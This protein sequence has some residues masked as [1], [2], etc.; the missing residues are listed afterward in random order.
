MRKVILF[1][2]SS[3]DG[4]IASISG[5]VD[6]LFHDQ[7]YGYSSFIA[8]VD[9]VV[10]GRRTYEQILTFGDYPYPGT[11]GYVF[12]KTR[13]GERDANVEFVSGDVA[14]FIADLKAVPGKNI[15]LV[16]GGQLNGAF[17]QQ[18][19]I[20]EFVVSTTSPGNSRGGHPPVSGR[21]GRPRI[22]LATL[23]FVRGRLGP[24][25]LRPEFLTLASDNDHSSS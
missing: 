14:R 25:N 7:D 11:T 16:G 20:D 6:W 17:L 19:L 3:L 21:N 8:G 10:M 13:S 15:W 12:S 4:F 1:I 5:D 22:E 18:G 23:R 2:A 9:T 24:T